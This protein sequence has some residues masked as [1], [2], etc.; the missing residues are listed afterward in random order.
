[1]TGPFELEFDMSA[2]A[3]LDEFALLA[4]QDYNL[5]NRGS[6]F[7]HFRGG[8]HAVF[9]RVYGV[10]AHYAAVHGWTGESWSQTAEYHLASIFFGMDSAI[11]CLVFALN[12]LGWGAGSEF[13]DVSD[14][15][16]LRRVRVEDVTGDRPIA[17]FVDLFPEISATFARHEATIRT[18]VEQH[19]VSKHRETIFAGGALRD[20]P[21]DGYFQSFGVAPGGSAAASI[22][23]MEEILLLEDLKTPA[24]KRESQEYDPEMSLEAVGKR[25]VNLMTESTQTALAD[26]HTNIPLKV[27]TLR[28]PT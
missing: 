11:E 19:D 5:G 21:P 2:L 25:F 1:M 27:R 17:G 23:P 28:R 7:T 20:D 24:S 13:R 6:W 4:R 9:N 12:A 16:A 14:S 26:A 18:I 8:A 3:A 22:T 15:C 10:G